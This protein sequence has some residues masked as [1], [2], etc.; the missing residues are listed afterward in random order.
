MI[1]NG[2][3]VLQEDCHNIG[4]KVG[5]M[6]SVKVGNISSCDG[7]ALPGGR[8]LMSELDAG[9]TKVGLQQLWNKSNQKLQPRRLTFIY[10]AYHNC[11][12]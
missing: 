9:Y 10:N 7:S 5:N 8:I 2:R 3:Q 12:S 6:A 4:V 11:Q 1:Q